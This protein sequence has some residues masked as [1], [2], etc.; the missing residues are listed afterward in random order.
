MTTFGQ[1]GDEFIYFSGPRLLVLDNNASRSPTWAVYLH[2]K[3]GGNEAKVVQ[4]VSRVVKPKQ[5]DKTNHSSH[6]RSCQTRWSKHRIAI[7]VIAPRKKQL[8]AQSPNEP[9]HPVEIYHRGSRSTWQRVPNETA[10]LFWMRV[11]Q[12][13]DRVGSRRWGN[14]QLFVSSV[15]IQCR[16][17]RRHIYKLP[18]RMNSPAQPFTWAQRKLASRR[19][20]HP[21]DPR[22][23]EP[24]TL[25]KRPQ[26]NL[27]W[28]TKCRV[29]LTFTRRNSDEH[30]TS[31]PVSILQEKVRPPQRLWMVPSTNDRQLLY[32]SSSPKAQ[33]YPRPA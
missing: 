3:H 15:Q 28:R 13:N 31:A 25:I 24:D 11:H 27:V 8:K 32:R 14:S 20:Q 16:Q 19:I 18:W 10:Q 33:H 30:R 23:E 17:Q 29:H 7:V 9:C 12:H 2:P 26:I 4:L 6:C 21:P 5:L 1:V 22:S